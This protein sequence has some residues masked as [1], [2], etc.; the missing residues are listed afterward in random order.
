MKRTEEWGVVVVLVDPDNI[1]QV[2][3]TMAS[4]DCLLVESRQQLRPS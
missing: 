2:G 4:C 3:D 1:M